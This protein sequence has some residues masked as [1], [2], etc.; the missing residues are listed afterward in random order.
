MRNKSK[1]Q[2]TGARSEL[3]IV[4]A[5][6]ILSVIVALIHILDVFHLLF[7]PTPFL[8]V[9]L[10]IIIDIIAASIIGLI[11]ITLLRKSEVKQ[12]ESEQ[13]FKILFEGAIDGM[14]LADIKTRM[15][16][17]CNRAMSEM[18]GYEPDEIKKIRIDEIHPK[19]A[20]PFV[21]D[22]VR[23]Q[24]AKEISIAENLPVKRSNEMS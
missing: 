22:Q 11:A 21:L 17:M 24:V 15:F 14:L 2:V 3:I 23:K 13:R 18:L 19:D 6:A 9:L 1:E 8:S 10:E 5:I 16:Y 12:R 4:V 7:A 20:L